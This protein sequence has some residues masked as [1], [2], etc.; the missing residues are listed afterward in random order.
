MISAF[1]EGFSGARSIIDFAEECQVSIS[2]VCTPAT[3]AVVT[4][5]VTVDNLDADYAASNSEDICSYLVDDV[6][7][8]LGLLQV[9]SIQC[10]YDTNN[11][12]FTIS[13]ETE[14]TDDISVSVAQLEQDIADGDATFT[15]LNSALAEKIDAQVDPNQDT[16]GVSLQLLSSEEVEASAE[17]ENG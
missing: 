6:S 3:K 7:E 8:S 16:F 4:M 5:E 11:E 14:S 10:T 2:D 9:D 12:S 17:V 13:F 15:S 1:S